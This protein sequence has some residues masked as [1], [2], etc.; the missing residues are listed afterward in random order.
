MYIE[1]KL[2]ELIKKDITESK[3]W[4]VY[5]YNGIPIPRVSEILS[6]MLHEEHIVSWANSL[7]F[8]HKSYVRERNLAAEKGSAS[9]DI[10]EKFL[11]SKEIETDFSQYSHKIRQSVFN[12]YSGFIDWYNMMIDNT[13]SFNI[14]DIEK[15]LVCPY[16]GGTLDIHVEINS[17]SYIID[18]KTSNHMTYKYFLQ[19]AAYIYI[20]QSYYNTP[21]D[22]VIVLL[23][24][25]EYIQYTDYVLEASNPIHN[26]MISHSIDT[27]LSLVYAYYNKCILVDQYNTIFKEIIR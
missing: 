17:K 20:M 18:L 5:S 10:I 4:N 16:Y 15:Q 1:E 26:E 2:Q 6:S 24:N 23:L 13:S 12:C 22:G 9:H 7:G 8:K 21:I 25:K 19:L 3:K 14:L 27:F 11:Q